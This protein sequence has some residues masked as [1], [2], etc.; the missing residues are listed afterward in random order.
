MISHAKLPLSFWAEAVVH[1]ADIRNRLLSPR[2]Q[3]KASHEIMTGMKPRVDHL[4][5]FGSICWTFFPKKL[6]KKME[7]N[8]EQ[9]IVVGCL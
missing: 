8:S 7:S 5:I 2:N 4:K 6:R 1:A 9:R 3:H